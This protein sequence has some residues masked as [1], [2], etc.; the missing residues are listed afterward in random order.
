VG[1][2]LDRVRALA[3]EGA[4]RGEGG[5]H[6]GRAGYI[7]PRLE[8]DVDR[9]PDQPGE[10]FL[11]ALSRQPSPA[12]ARASGTVSAPKGRECETSRWSR[13]PARSGACAAWI[14]PLRHPRAQPAK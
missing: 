11:A 2:F 13:C 6:A 10:P 1:S 12:R 14:G 7:R 4:E 3:V 5:L 9:L 8:I